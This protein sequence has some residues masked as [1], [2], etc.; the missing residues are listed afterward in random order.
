MDS[1]DYAYVYILASGFRRFYVGI[2]TRLQP[3]IAEHKENAHPGS[4]THRYKINQLV[5][6]ERY[7]NISEAIA[8]EK[9]LKRWS[10]LKKS[11]LIIQHN[12]TWKDLSLEWNEPIFYKEPNKQ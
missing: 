11:N 12:P 2:T 1:S 6:F 7:A 9:Q 8:R 10:R 3:R 4:F 5:Y